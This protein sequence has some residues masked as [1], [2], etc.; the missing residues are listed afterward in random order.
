MLNIRNDCL[1][2]PGARVELLSSRH[3]PDKHRESNNCDHL[4]ARALF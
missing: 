3:T 2:L 1:T 4:W